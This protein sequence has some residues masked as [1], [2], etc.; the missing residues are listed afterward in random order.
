MSSIIDLKDEL[1][2][3]GTLKD[4]SS[5]LTEAS[6]AKI[7]KIRASFEKNREFFEEIT[8]VY[9]I[10]SANAHR[11]GAKATAKKE[12]VKMLTIAL[13]ANQ[14][15]YGN[16]NTMIMKNYMNDM[17]NSQSDMVIVGKTGH[18]FMETQRGIRPYK[19]IVFEKDYPSEKEVRSILN[20]IKEYNKVSIYYPK[21]VTLLQ[22][23]VGVSDI[24]Q[25]VDTSG[26]EAEEEH[27]LFEPEIDKINDFFERQVRT[28]LFFRVMLETDLSRTAS[29]LIAMSA[30]EERS[31]VMMKEKHTEMV[32]LQRSLI[33]AQ[34]LAT[35]AGLSKWQKH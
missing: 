26:K 11:L 35:F 10:V 6:S 5:A 8:H 3:L 24:T 14:H 12:A 17:Q 16:Q 30:A 34:L 23:T 4:I 9:H 7:K 27:V 28:V 31:E 13:T 20:L 32:K 25:A 33:N 15:F 22:Q 1:G 19:K 29:R 2:E 21:F 18:E